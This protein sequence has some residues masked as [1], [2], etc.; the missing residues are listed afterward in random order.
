MEET[1]KP[2]TTFLKVL[3]YI[4]FIGSSWNMFAGLSNATSQPSMERV[5]SFDRIFDSIVD[6]KEETQQMIAMINDY[7]E[8]L[9][10]NIVNYGAVEFMLYAISIIGIYLMYK[11]RRVGFLVYMIV[12]ILLLGSPILFGGYSSFTVSITIFYG[13]ITMIFFALYSTQLKYMDTD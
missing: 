1:K 6:E 4:S 3:L 2:R 5:E 8:N 7:V 11:S 10:I 9:N 13:F 12:Q